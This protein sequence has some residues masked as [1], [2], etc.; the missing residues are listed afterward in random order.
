MPGPVSSQPPDA[1]QRHRLWQRKYPA[2]I[3]HTH[4]PRTP[5]ATHQLGFSMPQAM[6]KTS[7]KRGVVDLHIT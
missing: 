6:A 1:A 4:R 2:C 3:P 5:L 7:R